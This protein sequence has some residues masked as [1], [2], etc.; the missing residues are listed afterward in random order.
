M[1]NG[2]VSF[3]WGLAGT[4]RMKDMNKAILTLNFNR[5]RLLKAKCFKVPQS[6]INIQSYA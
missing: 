1:W 4:R 6:Y 3:K 5:S 2:Q